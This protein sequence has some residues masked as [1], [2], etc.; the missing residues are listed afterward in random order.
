MPAEWPVS[1]KVAAS[2]KSQPMAVK[3]VRSTEGQQPEVKR[4]ATTQAVQQYVS[5]ASV[6]EKKD[7]GKHTVMKAEVE[8]ICTA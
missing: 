6:L 5:Y 1:S 2:T 7:S 3:R 8:D 4:T